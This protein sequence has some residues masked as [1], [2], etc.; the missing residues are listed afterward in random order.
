MTL[1]DQ[2]KKQLKY[3]F[4][5]T[6]FP[7]NDLTTA[8]CNSK[9]NLR[10][11]W[12][13][14]QIIAWIALL[15]PLI[16]LLSLKLLPSFRFC[17]KIICMTVGVKTFSIY[18]RFY[19]TKQG[20]VGERGEWTDVNYGG[21]VRSSQAAAIWD[22]KCPSD[23]RGQYLTLLKESEAHFI[24]AIIFNLNFVTS[25]G[26][27]SGAAKKLRAEREI[28]KNTEKLKNWKWQMTNE[29]FWPKICNATKNG[30]KIGLR[31]R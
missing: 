21:F 7:R 23:C 4:V 15:K 11:E 19:L 24:I 20:T 29:R 27:K 5:Y 28:N 31:Y 16:L 8:I 30:G 25:L 3:H 14:W 12:S 2:H 9:C 17:K 10:C 26:L 1:N 18:I 13:F 6:F 22:K